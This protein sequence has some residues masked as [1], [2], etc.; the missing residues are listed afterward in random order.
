MQSRTGE[1]EGVREKSSHAP[2]HGVGTPWTVEAHYGAQLFGEYVQ[3][4]R[5]EESHAAEERGG[6][7][8]VSAGAVGEEV[9]PRFVHGGALRVSHAG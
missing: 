6:Q 7:S 2:Y 8:L 3:G 4:E 9:V 1:K 5:G